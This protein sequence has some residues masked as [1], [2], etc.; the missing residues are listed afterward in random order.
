M[1]RL[2]CIGNGRVVLPHRVIPNGAVV[3]RDGHIE[4]VLENPTNQS[5]CELLDAQ[6]GI[7]MPGFIDMHLH[8]GGGADF[9]DGTLD[10]F[11]TIARTHLIHGTTAMTPTT[12]TA[13][14]EEVE[15]LIDTYHQVKR[16]GTEGA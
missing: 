16:E 6:G 13:P 12:M 2:L 11:R 3:V 4:A 5:C 8:G 10:S 15:M 1:S 9:M 14:D 7:I